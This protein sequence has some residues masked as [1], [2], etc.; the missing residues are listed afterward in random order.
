MH[1][2]LVYWLNGDLSWLEYTKRWPLGHNTRLKSL[3]V[4]QTQ[5]N[6]FNT[7]SSL[8]SNFVGDIHFACIARLLGYQGIAVVIEELLKIIKS[9]VSLPFPLHPL[10]PLLSSPPLSSLLFS[11]PVFSS[12]RLFYPLLSP[13]SLLPSRPLHSLAQVLTGHCGLASGSTPAV[14]HSADR[15]HA[16]E[17][18]P[19]ALWVRLHWYGCVTLLGRGQKTEGGGALIH[20]ISLSTPPPTR[21]STPRSSVPTTVDPCPCI[22]PSIHVSLPVVSIYPST[23]NKPFDQVHNHNAR[24]LLFTTIFRAPSAL[25]LSF[26]RS[27]CY[28]LLTF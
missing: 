6:I 16:Q 5:N 17:M 20:P 4:L 13:S 9:L 18:R 26:P 19:A 2:Q 23:P 3:L 14:H 11:S 28:F 12:P 7:I 1:C 27:K 22:H 21:P 8:Y 15:W 24:H 25:T 10:S